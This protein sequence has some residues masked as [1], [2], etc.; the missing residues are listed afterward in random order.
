MQPGKLSRVVKVLR[1][2]GWLAILMAVH[3]PFLIAYLGGLW[4]HTHY[5]FFPFAIGAFVWLFATRRNEEPERWTWPTRILIAVDVV[6]LAVQPF[7]YSP[8]LAAAGLVALL[9]AWCLA[10]RDDGYDRRLT[11]LVLLPLL[12][13]RLPLM[14][15][16]Q[17]IHWLQRLTTSFAS[18]LM[19]RM[20][21]LHFREGNILQFPSKSFMVEEACSG[22]QSL[23]TI[24]FLAA[25]VIC[26]KRR[27]VIH[28]TVLLASGFFFAGI[29]NTLRVFSVASA[30]DKYAID[31][32]S[33][34]SHDVLGYICLAVAAV[35]LMSADAFL[36]FFF[37][38]FTDE[39]QPKDVEQSFHNPLIRLWN[40]LV[41]VVP[42]PTGSQPK[43]SSQASARQ[44]SD[45]GA[46][47]ERPK[48]SS[49]REL[50]NPRKCF[51]FGFDFLECWYRSRTYGRLLAGLPFLAATVGG[52][53]LVG[54]LRHASDAPIIA[55][56]EN[57][58]DTASG[59]DQETK[60]E[61]YL[62][63]L[64]SLR[65][66]DFRYRFRL[67]EFLFKQGRQNEGLSEIIR[68]A[69]ETGLGHADARMWL[70]RQ[71]M[72]PQPVQS[73]SLDQ[74]EKQLQA[75]VQQVP[76]DIEAHQLLAK[77]YAGRSDWMLAEQHLS[78]AAG[79][80]PEL[81]LALARLRKRRNTSPDD[82]LI[83]A[84]R[85]VVALSEQLEK[86]RANSKLRVELAEAMVL[87]GRGASG[88]E[89][90]VSG[91]IQQKDDPVLTHALSE[92]D[93]MMVDRRLTESPQNR[94]VCVP[95]VATALERDP[96]SAIAVQMLVRL[97]SMGAEISSVSF[98]KA[99][100][101]WQKEIKE[102]P[103]DNTRILLSQILLLSG[104][105][106]KA[107]ET[108]RPAL[109][110]HPELRLN[111]ARLLKQSGKT[112]ESA[113]L[114]NLLVTESQ[115]QLEQ[116]PK[117]T[118]AAT[119]LGEALLVLGRPEDV[120]QLLITFAADPA[121]SRIP[122]DAGL[123]A[124]YGWACLGCYDKLTESN[125]ELR[126]PTDA[127][128]I[129]ASAP[130]ANSTAS[131]GEPQIAINAADA[132]TSRAEGPE[133][134]VLLELLA[135][136]V[137]CQS[138]T[139]QAIDRISRLSLSS[140]P[141]AAGAENLVR[142]LRL[143]GPYGGPVLNQL[144]MHALLMNRFDKATSY[145]ELA[146]IQT[147]GRDPMILNNLAIAI[148]RSDAGSKGKALERANETLALLPDHPDALATR[149]EIYVAME[150]WPEAI[151]DLTESLKLRSRN[152]EVHRL[153]EKAYTGLPDPQMA[154]EHRQRA[155]ELEAAE[156]ADPKTT[157]GS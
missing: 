12:V 76:T 37:D 102:T 75:V 11:Y 31:L 60:R 144:G 89:V 133:P 69:P 23:F 50:L 42:I 14:Y 62:R 68:L 127:G 70:V 105:P 97:Q 3:V 96:S 83:A 45:R 85:A 7:Q 155:S 131:N 48:Y 72:Q 95:V 28:G 38:P 98:Q 111:F 64:N 90:L 135:D 74:I 29:M 17:L 93:L 139:N 128:S 49:W 5:Q 91:L 130:I 44:G 138:T 121:T 142:Q 126:R 143:E 114:L 106:E 99:L 81:N 21:M 132:S 19:H 119:Q 146:N 67:A 107:A 57:A 33:G 104:D 61:T 27:S 80:M 43:N 22:V 86:D 20:G 53:F 157:T 54:W 82:L 26:L 116:D 136:A 147:R 117:D 58:F 137:A 87:A 92:F 25:L 123:A 100:D 40:R 153:L 71:A 16:E 6:C 13:V 34:I 36:G 141:A 1:R 152:A 150:R 110:Q 140:H 125:V 59:H 73:L 8:W 46:D 148:I 32:S 149:G 30:W 55:A 4:R 134:A 63:A 151:A 101:Y 15:D 41:A 109:D 108:I 47:A 18:S 122:T 52:I 112:E 129:P 94:D 145:L 9:T 66:L 24:L 118:A 84:Q 2:R 156:V 79:I 35:M 103:D 65:P 77:L 124:L 39:F 88:R 115:S 154:E 120:R 78:Q 10:S 51:R 56:Y 113:I